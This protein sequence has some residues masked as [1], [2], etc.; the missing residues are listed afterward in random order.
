MAVQAWWYSGDR[1]G[2]EFIYSDEQIARL[3]ESDGRAEIRQPDIVM[4]SLT[5]TPVASVTPA[6]VID[7]VETSRVADPVRTP[8]VEQTPQSGAPQTPAPAPQTS[9]P[10]APA[11]AASQR[12]ELPRTAGPLPLAFL[13]G[14]GAI[15]AGFWM[16]RRGRAHS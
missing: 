9:D 14:I 5:P 2:Y 7:E 13:A 11:P 1:Y 3:G 10:A 16:S 4:A 8:A 12:D 15:A 6:P